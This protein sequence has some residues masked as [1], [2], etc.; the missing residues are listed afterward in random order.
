[1]SMN[2]R[3]RQFLPFDAL[4]GLKEALRLKEY[5][6]ERIMKKDISD[7]KISYISRMLGQITKND[8]VYLKYYDDGHYFQVEGKCKIDYNKFLIKF[9]EKTIRFENIYD[10]KI[11]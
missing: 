7:E 10:I 8:Y 3:A 11:K 2:D 5:E 9:E 1:M 4:K 6:H